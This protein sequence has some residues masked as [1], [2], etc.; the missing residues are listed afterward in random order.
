MFIHNDFGSH[1]DLTIYLN[2]NWKS[3]IHMDFAMCKLFTFNACILTWFDVEE[4]S[5]YNS[6]SIIIYI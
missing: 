6:L 2:G 1:N 4:I 5:N 3:I